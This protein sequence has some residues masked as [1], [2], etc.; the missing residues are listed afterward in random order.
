MLAASARASDLDNL[1]TTISG[2]VAWGL[3]YPGLQ[4]CHTPPT[5]KPVNLL[6]LQSGST[7]L[8]MLPDQRCVVRF[9]VRAG[10][11]F[12]YSV[13]PINPGWGKDDYAETE[14]KNKPSAARS[15]IVF[16]AGINRFCVP[17]EPSDTRA[18]EHAVTEDA[19]KA[20]SVGEKVTLWLPRVCR[21]DPS[22]LI[23]GQYPL[24]KEPL[25]SVFTR[26]EQ[27]IWAIELLP[28]S[29]PHTERLRRAAT[30][31]IIV[32]GRARVNV[33]R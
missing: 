18:L 30:K 2:A 16:R 23:L 33:Q 25:V 29:Y 14:F 15:A 21:G 10:R 3:R 12:P 19:A 8:A 13:S 20:T 4:S 11:F 7:G 32:T 24:D 17:N 6:I 5:G 28:R 1:K 31:K 22:A 9:F 27:H 26:N